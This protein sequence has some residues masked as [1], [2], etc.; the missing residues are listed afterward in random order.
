M[1]ILNNFTS[2]LGG[3][4]LSTAEKMHL[5]IGR[6]AVVQLT[7]GHKNLWRVLLVDKDNK[8]VA[9][10]PDEMPGYPS[11]ATAYIMAQGIKAFSDDE[12]LIR[13]Q[14]AN[15]EVAEHYLSC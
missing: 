4:Q 11:E 10:K 6:V 9:I 13:P 12:I 15:T 1:E 2:D 3:L 7:P 8:I 14:E 5:K